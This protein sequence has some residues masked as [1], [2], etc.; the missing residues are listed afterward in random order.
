MVCLSALAGR[1]AAQAAAGTG[2]GTGLGAGGI[3]ND[4]F[5]FYYAIYLP[6]QQLQSMR[7]GPL[8]AVN[9]AMGS[10]AILRTAWIDDRFITP[11]RPTPTNTIRFIRI[12]NRARNAIARTSRFMQDPSNANGAGPSLYFNRAHEYFPDLASRQARRPNAN[13]A[14]RRGGGPR[15]GRGGGGGM[16]AAWA[17]AWVAAWVAGRWHGWRHGAAWVAACFRGPI[18]RPG[19][20]LAPVLVFPRLN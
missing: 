13:T 9:D 18:R 19:Q 10:T 4:P 14:G 12:L 17:V 16:G 1:A 3:I 2:L 7:P 5:T 11:Y 15:S 20:I 8:D 6:N